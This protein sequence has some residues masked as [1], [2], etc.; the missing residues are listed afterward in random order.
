MCVYENNIKYTTFLSHKYF[1]IA[2]FHL[3]MYPLKTY[4]LNLDQALW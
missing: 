4:L 3:F 2:T 1:Y